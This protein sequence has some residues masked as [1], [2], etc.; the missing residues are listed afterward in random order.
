MPIPLCCHG[1]CIHAFLHN[2]VHNTLEEGV[3]I[4]QKFGLVSAVLLVLPW[5]WL[6]QV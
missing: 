6:S 4:A 3:S 2:T 5:G 1:L